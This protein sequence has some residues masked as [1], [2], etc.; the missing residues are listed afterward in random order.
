M[1]EGQPSWIS[2][3]VGDTQLYNQAAPK[4][5]TVS[6]AVNVIKSLRWPG[7]VTVSKG[8]K[9]TNIYVGH[10]LKFGASSYNPVE[11]PSVNA[12]PDEDDEKDEPN[13]KTEPAPAD[14]DN[15]DKD[16]DDKGDE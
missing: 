3:V 13:P 12:D 4:E 10:G 6:Y 5:G 14:E 11:P 8:G 1:F 16:E 15:T 7:A 2:K 9:F